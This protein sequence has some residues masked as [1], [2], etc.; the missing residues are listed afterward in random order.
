MTVQVTALRSGTGA[1]VFN[2]F[3]KDRVGVGISLDKDF[4][5]AVVYVAHPALEPEAL[6]R[7]ENPGLELAAGDLA[8]NDA[9]VALHGVFPRNSM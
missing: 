2:R 1:S 8:F 9:G 6:G 3:L 7:V 5:L 4:G